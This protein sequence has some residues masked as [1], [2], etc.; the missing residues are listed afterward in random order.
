M[1]YAHHALMT[2][3]R[4][5]GTSIFVFKTQGTKTN[6]RGASLEQWG[7]L[8]LE[9]AGLKTSSSS[10]GWYRSL[11]A[12]S[13]RNT[14]PD[15]CLEKESNTHPFLSPGFVVDDR[16]NRQIRH[17]TKVKLLRNKHLKLQA[18]QVIMNVLYYFERERDNGGA[19]A[20]FTSVMQRTAE[21]CGRS[22][23]TLTNIKKRFHD[24]APNQPELEFLVRKKN[25]DVDRLS[26]KE[27]AYESKVRKIDPQGGVEILRKL[28]RQVLKTEKSDPTFRYPSNPFSF[29]ED[30]SAVR[31]TISLLRELIA[32]FDDSIHGGSYKKINSKIAHA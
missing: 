30:I 32:D 19:C 28:L 23:R 6:A 14:L 10:L 9:L 11:L 7:D 16:R 25:H 12:L 15:I 29:E 3:T 26:S 27:L 21:A 13:K 31:E 20:P 2:P 17:L 24:A 1:T 5:A 4:G 8:L 18:Q 22:D